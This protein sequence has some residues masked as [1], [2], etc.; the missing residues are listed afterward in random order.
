MPDRSLLPLTIMVA[1]QSLASAVTGI[2]LPNY[3]LQI[4]MSITQISALIGVTMLLV[5]LVPL[6]T[7]K[8]LPRHFERLLPI[9]I[10]LG[11]VFY[12]LLMFV[13]SPLV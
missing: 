8:L 6:L 12:A 4:G 1:F 11:M 5:G 13:K 10:F 3:Y 7:L 2:F 9:G